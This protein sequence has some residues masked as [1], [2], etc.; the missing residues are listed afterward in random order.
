MWMQVHISLTALEDAP[1]AGMQALALPGGGSSKEGGISKKGGGGK[2]AKKG[3]D[4]DS[5]E[6]D[7]QV[8]VRKGSKCMI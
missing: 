1:L 3:A 2:G 8:R 5:E 4:S 6:E 7:M